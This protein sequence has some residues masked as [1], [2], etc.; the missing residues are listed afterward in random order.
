MTKLAIFSER[1]KSVYV[2]L[3]DLVK[4]FQTSSYYLV[5]TCTIRLRYSRERASQSLPKF[6]QRLEHIF[7]KKHRLKLSR[8]V[9]ASSTSSTC[10]LALPRGRRGQRLRRRRTPKRTECTW[11][12]ARMRA[13]GTRTGCNNGRNS[14]RRPRREDRL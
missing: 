5:F 11:H 3:V 12:Q 10:R 1:C 6:S 4:S 8:I 7:R 2:N 13:P 9:I 14:F